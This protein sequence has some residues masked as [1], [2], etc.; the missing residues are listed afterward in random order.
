MPS[1]TFFNLP[2]DKQDQI[3]S[4]SIKVF[5]KGNYNE[6]KISDLIRSAGIPR[7]SFYDYFEDKMDLYKY[8]IDL[9]GTKKATYLESVPQSEDFFE[10][11]KRIM[12]SS[13]KFL[14]YEPELDAIA[15]NFLSDPQ[16][17]NELYGTTNVQTQDAFSNMLRKGINSGSVRPDIDIAFISKT[18]QILSMGLMIDG[19]SEEKNTPDQVITEMAYKMTEFIRVG[20]GN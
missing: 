10:E 17:I 11:L 12:L 9:I 4:Q 16:L 1:K 2:S 20:I 13:V 6:I 19:L 7:T 18:L 8:I 15:K 3:I 14:A 5:A